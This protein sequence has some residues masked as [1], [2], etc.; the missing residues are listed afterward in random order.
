MKLS[1]EPVPRAWVRLLRPMVRCLPFPD[2]SRTRPLYT[3][4]IF[5]SFLPRYT[6][7]NTVEETFCRIFLIL[8]ASAAQNYAF[9]K[10]ERLSD[11]KGSVSGHTNMENVPE[12]SS[13]KN[14]TT[15]FKDSTR[16]HFQCQQ[17]MSESSPSATVLKQ[18]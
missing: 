14:W 4:S 1:L 10:P 11:H 3:G 9:P 7:L 18:H 5:S 2:S 12:I 16:R 6:P 15:I 13:N 8:R 17:P